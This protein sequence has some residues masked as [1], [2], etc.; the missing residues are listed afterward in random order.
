MEL[1]LPTG[2]PV[3][4]TTSTAH[5]ALAKAI[6]SRAVGT[7]LKVVA[8]KIFGCAFAQWSLCVNFVFSSKRMKKES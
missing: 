4:Q 8:T 2:W 5:P 1:A 7:Q 6:A 3:G